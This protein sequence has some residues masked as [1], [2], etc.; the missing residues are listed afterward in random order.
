MSTIDLIHLG[1]FRYTVSDDNSVRKLCVIG[2]DTSDYQQFK[3]ICVDVTPEQELQKVY[4]DSGW[5]NYVK[6]SKVKNT[7]S[8]RAVKEYSENELFKN[9]W[10]AYYKRKE[11]IKNQAEYMC[12]KMKKEMMCNFDIE[13]DEEN[14]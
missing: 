8:P 2:I 11:Q 5:Y 13:K 4:D 6:V 9:L 14:D 10:D 3:Y 1:D 12:K 7:D